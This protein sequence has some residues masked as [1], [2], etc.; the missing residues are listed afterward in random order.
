MVNRVNKN[1]KTTFVG[2]VTPSG[3]GFFYS[4]PFKSNTEAGQRLTIR[5]SKNATIEL[6]G[7]QINSLLRVIRTARSS[8]SRR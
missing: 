5:G 1:N 8:A 6:T 2:N 3:L 7:S 4:V